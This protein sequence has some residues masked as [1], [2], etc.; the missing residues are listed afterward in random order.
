MG[1]IFAHTAQKGYRSEK[2]FN[3]I[4]DVRTAENT[5]T[6]TP[7]RPH[8]ELLAQGCGRIAEFLAE[9]PLNEQREG[10]SST[11]SDIE[12]HRLSHNNIYRRL[13]M[14]LEEMPAE[15]IPML[16]AT[17]LNSCTKSLNKACCWVG[18]EIG[19]NQR[20]SRRDLTL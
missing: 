20:S 19:F 16:K 6:K 8:G 15:T 4:Q 18:L 14:M 12:Q 5:T 3:Y 11:H 9:A 13:V 1:G 7:E 10:L 2:V 17:N